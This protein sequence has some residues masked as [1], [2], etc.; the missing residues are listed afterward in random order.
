MFDVDRN[1]GVEAGAEVS[2]NLVL[3][4]LV[5]SNRALFDACRE[6]L[7]Q[8]CP[9]GYDLQLF[10]PSDQHPDHFDIYIWDSESS[11][12]LPAPM[13]VPGSP[14]KLVIASKESLSALRR[15]LPH[16]DFVF[17]QSPVT[18]LSLR[19]VLE[20]VVARLQLGQDEPKSSS[21]LNTERDQIFQKLLETNL[22]L[23]EYDRDRT[24]FMSRAIHD[25]RVPLMA[26]QGYCGLLLAGELGSVNPEQTRI[27][28]K[29]QRSL[30]RLGGLVAAMMDLGVGSQAPSHLKVENASIESCVKQAI[31]ELLPLT[32]Q[33]DISLTHEV[34]APSGI[35]M[36]DPHQI[37]QVLVNLLENS[38]KFTPR[39]GKIE[40]RAYSVN[41]QELR[42]IGLTE[43]AGYRI[44]IADNGPGVNP[45]HMAH[46][47]DEYTSY[48][49]AS[50]RSGA[51]LGLAI[52]RMIVNAHNGRILANSNE[53]GATFS[54]V[55]PFVQP[56]HAPGSD[57]Q[58]SHATAHSSL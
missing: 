21:R 19:V 8:L 26:I 42:H 39:R 41:A 46:I 44:D 52:C 51:G 28:G 43:T 18:A 57:L 10:A 9:C 56:Q 45:E 12:S 54:L 7:D 58:R 31:H 4:C 35:L 1:S 53:A 32:T 22:K 24:N 29:M 13:S 27:L 33:K 14:S 48:D 20:S 23:Q 38:Y 40:I 47:F 25:V 3:L 49:G 11:S 15:D 37:E 36:F 5:S 55:L 30:T 17:L 34:V 50:D 6:I 2:E 16:Q